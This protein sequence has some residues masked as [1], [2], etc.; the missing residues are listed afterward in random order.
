[1]ANVVNSASFPDGSI[2]TTSTRTP[3][4]PAPNVGKTFSPTP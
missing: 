4:A 3:G 2:T 1:M